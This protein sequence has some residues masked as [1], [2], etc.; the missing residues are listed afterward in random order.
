MST[1]ILVVDDDPDIRDVVADTLR[2]DGYEVCTAADGREAMA[3]IR[4]GRPRLVLLD[5]QMPSMTGWEVVER[6]R[7]EGIAVPVVFMTAGLRARA[8]AERHGVA[9]YLAKPFG[10]DDLTALV[11]RFV[12]GP[13]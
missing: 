7:A 4:E 11:T 2:D 10:L 5:L 9:G 1:C 3:H 13:A 6:L 8:E 12:P